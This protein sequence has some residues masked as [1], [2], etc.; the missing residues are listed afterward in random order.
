MLKMSCL[1]VNY[2]NLYL[3]DSALG[4]G[5]GKKEICGVF[6]V[7]CLFVKNFAVCLARL[8]CADFSV[9]SRE[10]VLFPGM[11]IFYEK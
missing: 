8:H 2:Y 5:K 11:P 1:K 10:Y 7:L 6:D 9:G 3:E 4:G